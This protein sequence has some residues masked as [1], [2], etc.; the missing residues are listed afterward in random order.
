MLSFSPSSASL[1]AAAAAAAAGVDV[2]TG[3]TRVRFSTEA[4]ET[5]SDPRSPRPIRTNP[6]IPPSD[7]A[8]FRRHGLARV[9]TVNRHLNEMA[10]LEPQPQNLTDMARLAARRVVDRLEAFE[11]SPLFKELQEKVDLVSEQQEEDQEAWSDLKL[12]VD[13]LSDCHDDLTENVN[14]GIDRLNAYGERLDSAAEI[15]SDKIHELEDRI[16]LAEYVGIVALGILAG[17]VVILVCK[18]S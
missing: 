9:E 11:Q 12:R 5:S 18:K 14:R 17:V 2:A 10:G 7:S 4:E 8:L 15:V 6:R 3:P 13:S 1:P 16:R